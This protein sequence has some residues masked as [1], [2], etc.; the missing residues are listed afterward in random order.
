M[1]TCTYLLPKTEHRITLPLK[2]G[3]H[4]ICELS[5]CN[6]TMLYDSEQVKKL[7]SQVVKD[8][9]LSVVSEGSFEFSPYGFT[10]FFLLEESHTSI[11]TWPEYGYCAIDLFTCN[12]HINTEPFFLTLKNVFE[13]KHMSIQ[14]IERGIKE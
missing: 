6:S 3:E 12:L 13:A 10:G 5:G 11:H 9:N 1:N 8:S 4:F 14:M 2:L 7:F